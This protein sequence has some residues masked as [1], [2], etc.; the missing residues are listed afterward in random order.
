[1]GGTRERRVRTRIIAASNLDLDERARAGQFR[2]DLLYRLNAFTVKIPPLRERGDDAVLIARA[3]LDRLA[4]RYARSQ[5]SLAPEA[6]EAIRQHNWPGNVRELLNAVQRA[7]MLADEAILG[8]HDLGLANP[9]PRAQTTKTGVGSDG[10]VFDFENGVHTL[11]EVEKALVMQALLFT[12]GNVS[13][14]ARLIGLQRSSLR[15]RIEQ[16]QLERYVSEVAKQ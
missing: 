7:Q 3:A 12:K 16:Y 6:E 8:P 5:L 13:R 15:Y 10:L 2:R 9:L 11:E 14:A 1:V 4:K